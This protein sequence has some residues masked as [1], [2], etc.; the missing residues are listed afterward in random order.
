ME[1][2]FDKITFREGFSYVEH[3]I[4][5]GPFSGNEIWECQIIYII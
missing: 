1:Q 2:Y 5:S 3:E 4:K